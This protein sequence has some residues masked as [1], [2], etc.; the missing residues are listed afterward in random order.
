MI[1]S[2]FSVPFSFCYSCEAGGSCSATTRLI[3][4]YFLLVDTINY[5]ACY[6]RTRQVVGETLE[7]ERISFNGGADRDLYDHFYNTNKTIQEP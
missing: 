1:S 6:S 7:L 2:N 5:L 4:R 3:R